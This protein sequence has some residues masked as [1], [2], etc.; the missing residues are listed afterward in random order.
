MLTDDMSSNKY[1]YF[2]HK[3]LIVKLINSITRL[4]LTISKFP[5][6]FFEKNKQ[7]EGSSICYIDILPPE[8]LIYI[9]CMLDY[10]DLVRKYLC[11]KI[12]LNFH[13]FL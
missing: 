1:T 13:F 8:I 4:K 3:T 2:L 10:K 12:N 11:V 5:N 6:Q 9:L 7:K